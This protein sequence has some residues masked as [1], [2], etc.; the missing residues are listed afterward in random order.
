MS[1]VNSSSA[2]ESDFNVTTQ[3]LCH[4]FWEEAAAELLLYGNM[5]HRQLSAISGPDKFR[6]PLAAST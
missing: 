3:K 2:I 5:D 6:R 4:H 1:P